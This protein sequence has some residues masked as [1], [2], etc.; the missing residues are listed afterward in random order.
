MTKSKSIYDNRQ[1]RIILVQN[2]LHQIFVGSKY[3]HE[4]TPLNL[5]RPFMNVMM[6]L[7][8]SRMIVSTV[9]WEPKSNEYKIVTCSVVDYTLGYIFKI[10]TEVENISPDDEDTYLIRIK[11]VDDDKKDEK[12]K[13]FFVLHKLPSEYNK[14]PEIIESGKPD[15]TLLQKFLDALNPNSDLDRNVIKWMNCVLDAWRS[16]DGKFFKTRNRGKRITE[17]ENI[18]I[19]PDTIAQLIGHVSQVLDG[20]YEG[21][22]DLS[23]LNKDVNNPRPNIFFALKTA[24]REIPRF[25]RGPEDALYKFRGYPYDI[26]I[27]IPETQKKD[28]CSFEDGV[29]ANGKIRNLISN[30]D[31]NL[32]RKKFVNERS[33]LDEPLSSGILTLPQIGKDN[34]NFQNP[35]PEMSRDEKKQKEERHILLI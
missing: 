21:A 10:K 1:S 16:P 26:R 15:F 34:S 27:I 12:R 2:L 28:W 11:N 13:Y 5:L 24:G 8:Q 19:D 32:I 9:E 3:S 14:E 22:R 33:V 17:N 31:I 35:N 4:N 29:D 30:D 20:L 18:K 6:L 7:F 23:L 25:N